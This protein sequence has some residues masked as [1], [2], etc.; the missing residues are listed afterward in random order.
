[1]LL[2]EVGKLKVYNDKLSYK[3]KSIDYYNIV[4]LGW[5]WISKTTNFVNT[6]SVTLTLYIN[7]SKPL[8][9]HGNTLYKTPKLVEA[10]KYIAQRTFEQRINLYL[11]QI[12]ENGYFTYEG[13][14]FYPNG[15]VLRNGKEYQLKNAEYEP[16]RIIIKQG[17]FLSSK[18][19]VKTLIDRDVM[20]NL[21]EFI[22]R[23]PGELK[24]NPLRLQSNIIDIFSMASKLSSVDSVVSAEEI[25]L[26]THFMK[27]VLS[28][29]E[30]QKKEAF[31]IF[32]NARY[33]SES[34]FEN[35]ARRFFGA[36]QADQNLLVM[37]TDLLFFIAI[38]DGEL[39]AEEELLIFE[40]I[41]IFG[42]NDCEFL[43]Y[44]IEQKNR[45]RREEYQKEE[46]EIRY[47]TILGVSRAATNTE[48]QTVYRQLVS[49][50]HPDKVHHL[51]KEFV[52]IAEV[53]IKEINE[54]YSYLKSAG[55]V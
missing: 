39:S 49:K 8:K 5:Y 18:L 15:Q 1:M 28:F 26:I 47:F 11:Y 16:F 53:K 13:V 6:Q 3:R 34:S 10:Y 45:K 43:K 31:E 25:Q 12:E 32:E 42:I 9:I 46:N 48:I 54:A 14:R 33:Q 55:H 17:G 27:S 37:V 38:S 50:Y 23:N 19:K 35:Y 36:N 22:V 7:G 30:N 29:N 41:T 51:G 52:E 4:H 40:V 21:F 44:K 2:I 24:A 20:L